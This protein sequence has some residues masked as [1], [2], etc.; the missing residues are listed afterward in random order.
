MRTS[1]TT[2]RSTVSEVGEQQGEALAK[3]LA[4]D[5]NP[6]GPIVKI[7]G[8]PKDNNAKFFNEGAIGVFEDEGIEIARGVRHPRL[9]G[10]ERPAR[11]GAGDHRGRQGRLRRRLRGQRWHRRRR[12]R[13]AQGGRASIPGRSRSPVR[14]PS[15]PEIQRIIDGEQ[16]MT[17]YKPIKPLAETAAEIAVALANG[18]DVPA[19]LING[20]EDN[21]TEQVPTAITRHDPGV[22]GQHQGHG[23]RRR[24]LVGRR[25]LHAA[26]RAGVQGRGHSVGRPRVPGS[27]RRGQKR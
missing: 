20:E 3:K 13:G 9:A 4:E 7:N 5:G 19:G 23:H 21:G 1:T 11:D 22:R 12:D 16:Y 18:E 26:V 6:Q 17:V 10:R 15:W 14:T 27:A 25:D 2:S 8:D 24:L